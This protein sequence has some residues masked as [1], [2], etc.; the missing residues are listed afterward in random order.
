MGEEM[1]F[2]HTVHTEKKVEK[3]RPY[4]VHCQKV[5]D[6]V[7]LRCVDM[8]RWTYVHFTLW[9][10]P[11]FLSLTSMLLSIS[12]RA[13]PPTSF[14]LFFLLA[15]LNMPSTPHSPFHECMNRVR[16]INTL[17]FKIFKSAH[18]IRDTRERSSRS[19][20]SAHKRHGAVKLRWGSQSGKT[21]PAL[22]NVKLNSNSVTS[23]PCNK[24]VEPST[25]L[26]KQT[27]FCFCFLESSHFPRSLCSQTL[28]NQQLLCNS[29]L[30]RC[31]HFIWANT[32]SCLWSTFQT[33]LWYPLPGAQLCKPRSGL[34]VYL[35]S[36][37]PSAS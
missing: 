25:Q 22:T 26:T 37:L 4:E 12:K 33:E 6:C 3:S 36:L 7:M 9:E 13:H 23:C 18:C 27:F 2:V 24:Y 20:E 30:S 29:L 11:F 32:S 34:C 15:N 35:P 19:W 14:F 31:S 21:F 17:H 10:L 1:V 16:K 5:N 28:N 8:C